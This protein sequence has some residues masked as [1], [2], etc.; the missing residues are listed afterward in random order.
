MNPEDNY[1]ADLAMVPT[2]TKCGPN[3]VREAAG[4]V[5]NKLSEKN[6]LN[7]FHV[8]QVCYNQRCQEV[9]S[10]KAFGTSDC[11][12]KCSS[13]GVGHGPYSIVRGANR[14]L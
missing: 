14:L 12:S 3:M 4:T 7:C 10:L 9:K 1:P 8:C 2:G 6:S 11:S 13:R 5:R